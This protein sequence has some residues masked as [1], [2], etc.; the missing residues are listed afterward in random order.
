MKTYLTSLYLVFSLW[1]MCPYG[2]K[3][4]EKIQGVSKAYSIQLAPTPKYPPQLAI[5]SL[6]FADKDGNQVINAYESAKI[7]L[8]IENNGQG[9]AYG[10]LPTLK[11]TSG[12]QGISF[13]NEIEPIA[14]LE[15]KENFAVEIELSASS[16]IKTALAIFQIGAIDA[17]GFEASQ[18]LLEVNTQA[19]QPPQLHLADY[20]FSSNTRKIQ[21]STPITLRLAIQN[22]GVGEAENV[23]VLC[24]LPKNV[25]A[26]GETSFSKGNL[27]YAEDTQVDLEFFTNS[28][29][30]SS[31][32]PIKVTVTESYGRYGFTKTVEATLEENTSKNQRLTVVQPTSKPEKLNPIAEIRLQSEVDKNI[33]SI[34]F[35][36]EDAIAVVIGNKDYEQASNVDYALND[37]LAMKKYLIGTMGFKPGNIFYYE[38]ATLSDFRTLFGTENNHKGKIYNSMKH[39]ASDIFV[40][41]SG[42]GAPG[43]AD[44]NGYFVPTN[45]DPNYV[46]PKRPITS[47]IRPSV[48]S[49]SALSPAGPNRCRL[50]ACQ[51]SLSDRPVSLSN[52]WISPS[53]APTWIVSPMAMRVWPGECTVMGAPAAVWP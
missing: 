36:N 35:K 3:A 45:S 1:I 47:A 16:S 48:R 44:K 7:T 42:H 25:F 14:K 39:H 52:R 26:A 30:A 22:K 53:G 29:Y 51:S 27:A 50:P 34:N 46:R 15:S 38:N 18:Q 20:L 21:K 6:K 11:E 9:V 40:F 33:P 49:E 10:V 8:Q 24:E 37:A 12:L 43:L 4:Q 41:Y 23:S 2:I 19:F 32:I 17:N 5:S 13:Q 31:T 28:Q